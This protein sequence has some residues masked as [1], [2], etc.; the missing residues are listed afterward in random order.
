MVAVIIAAS[1][2]MIFLSATRVSAT[3]HEIVVAGDSIALM[4]LR[5]MVEVVLDKRGHP[6]DEARKWLVQTH[7]ARITQVTS[8]MR[9]RAANFLFEF[10]RC[11]YFSEVS[12]CVAGHRSG[13][14]A[15]GNWD[16][17]RPE[18]SAIDATRGSTTA[19][20]RDLQNAAHVACGSNEWKW[21]VPSAPN[22]SAPRFQNGSSVD[23]GTCRGYIRGVLRPLMLESLS[24]CR[25]VDLTSFS[26]EAGGPC[27][28]PDG[29]HFASSPSCRNALYRSIMTLWV[30]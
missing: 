4:L 20:Q 13:I 28:I 21:V 19:F 9:V 10:R 15:M 23:R 26:L 18:N 1:L 8:V 22:C 30:E 14:L 16:M 25:I 11:Q 24:R 12:R 27:A 5:A 29:L 2:S 6:S 3:Q 17:L 7:G